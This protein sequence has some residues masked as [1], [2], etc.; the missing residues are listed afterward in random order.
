MSIQNLTR[1]ITFDNKLQSAVRCVLS[2]L[3]YLAATPALLNRTT[4]KHSLSALHLLTFF[5]IH[6]LANKILFAKI[7]FP[8][9]EMKTVVVYISFLRK[10]KISFSVTY[11]LGKFYI[12]DAFY[13]VLSKGF[14][15][16]FQFF[17]MLSIRFW[18]FLHKTFL[19]LSIF[20]RILDYVVVDSLNASP[21]KVIIFP[22]FI[23]TR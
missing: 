9:Q 21:H 5:T 8:L 23:L 13:T 11:T 20:S 17:I 15:I 2:V 7:K 19:I 22:K 1:W 18:N 4:T 12:L 3:I 16:W 14:T 10:L 6:P